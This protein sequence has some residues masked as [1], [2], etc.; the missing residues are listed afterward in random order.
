[1]FG[2][3]G[4]MLILLTVFV[5][6]TV[7]LFMA[8]VSI[9][10]RLVVNRRQADNAWSQIDVQ[11]KRRCDLIPNLVESVKG[12]AAHEK[13][14]FENVTK[15]RAGALNAAASGNQG[16]RIQA[17]TQLSG[18][19]RGFMLQVEQYPDLKAN[20]NFMALQQE[21]AETENRLSSARQD[22]NNV[23]TVYNTSREQFPANLI[24]G[25]FTFPAKDLWNITDA[26]ERETPKVKF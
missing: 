3:L 14:L 17:E 15:A 24:A 25:F 16:E 18:A 21:L 19:V 7:F 26:A 5:L 2:A 10:N 1:M 20:Q 4:I 6:G 23:A 8:G 9:Y 12:Y 11:L 22:Y 13:G